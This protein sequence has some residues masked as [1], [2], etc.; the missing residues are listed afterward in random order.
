MAID[1]TV[2]VIDPD[3]EYFRDR[4]RTDFPGIKVLTALCPDDVGDKIVY[5]DVLAAMSTMAST[6][7]VIK[8]SECA[9]ARATER[10]RGRKER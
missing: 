6:A 10:E 3:A 1:T 9:H 8:Q 4:L 7:F 2:L 5:A